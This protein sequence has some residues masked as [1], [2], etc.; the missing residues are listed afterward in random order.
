MRK[1]VRFF[2]KSRDGW[3][4]K[5]QEARAANKRLANQTRA[6]ERSRACWREKAESAQRE[7]RELKS[8]RKPADKSAESRG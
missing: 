6:V 5:C 1:L 4:A 3:K 7:L 8:Q 2:Q